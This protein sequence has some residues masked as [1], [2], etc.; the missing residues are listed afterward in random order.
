MGGKRKSSGK[1]NQKK[2]AQK[3]KKNKKN[4]AKRSKSKR[5]TNKKNKKKGNRSNKK[6]KQKKNKKKKNIK[7][8]KSTKRKSKKNKSKGKR[9]GS[10]S[11]RK[12]KRKNK[13]KKE[14]KQ[15]RKEKIKKKG[16]TVKNNRKSNGKPRQTTAKVNLTCLRDA[17]TYTKFL[18][19]NVINFLRRSTRLNRQNDLTNK[20]ASKKGEFKEPAARLIQAGGGDRSNLSCAGSTS[21][22]GAEQIKTLIRSVKKMLLPSTRQFPN[23]SLKQ[24]KEKMPVHAFKIKRLQRSKKFFESVKELMRPRLQQRLGLHASNRL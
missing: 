19:D 21:N 24:Q 11:K 12:S 1:K 2:K 17:I 3:K 16:R 13:N 4:K 14:K 5:K 23:A 6:G 8:R 15:K 22:K 7:K 9:K 10:K 20:K 18:K